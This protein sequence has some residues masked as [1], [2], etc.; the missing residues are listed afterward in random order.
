MPAPDGG[1]LYVFDRTG[2]HIRTLDALTSAVT[3]SFEYGDDGLVDA[4]TDGDGNRTQ[5]LR[6][7][8]GKPTEVIAPF[9]QTTSLLADNAG[10]LRRL[11]TPSGRESRMDYTPTGLLSA[12]SDPR[13]GVSEFTCDSI[14]R[15]IRDDDKGDG[16]K[17]LSRTDTPVSQLDANTFGEFEVTLATATGVG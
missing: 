9:G 14:G 1:E 16:F 12:I 15:L 10:D 4:V 5:I 3:L 6:D 2:R 7:D 11:T 17:T 13:G 8:L